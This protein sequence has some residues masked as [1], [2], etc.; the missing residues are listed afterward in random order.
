MSLSEKRLNLSLLFFSVAVACATYIFIKFFCVDVC[1][2]EGKRGFV[3]PIWSGSLGISSVLLFLALF[4]SRVFY[5]WLKYIASWFIPV[6]I[7][8]IANI[9]VYS[10][11]ILS[12]GRGEAAFQ[13]MALLGVITVI[14][15]IGYTVITRLRK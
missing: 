6:T 7:L 12:V 11:G 14:F 9:S 15:A 1:T 2:F 13:L 10:S 3:D 8:V 4:P 5:L